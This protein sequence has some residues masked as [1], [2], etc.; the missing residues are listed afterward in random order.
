MNIVPRL[1]TTVA[2]LLIATAII[3]PVTNSG[4][5]KKGGYN[6]PTGT[7]SGTVTINGQPCGKG[8]INF[9]NENIS[10]HGAAI[11]QTDGSYALKVGTSFSIPVG[12]YRVAIVGDDPTAPPPDPAALMSNPE[13]FKANESIPAKY[14]DPKTSGLLVVVKEGANPNTNFDLK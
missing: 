12:D 2:S 9:I 5:S 1:S 4:C 8:S 6:G 10:I 13:K 11:L 7:V 3:L 14:R